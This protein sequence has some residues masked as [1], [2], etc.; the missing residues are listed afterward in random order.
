MTGVPTEALRRSL[1][2]KPN[3]KHYTS[4]AFD[5][6]HDRGELLVAIVMGA[7][8]RIWETRLA[9][10]AKGN[11]TGV[12]PILVIEEGA[13]AAGQLLRLLTRAIAYLPPVDLARSED[14]RVGK[15]CVSQCKSRWSPFH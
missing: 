3:P 4:A 11:P 9:P 12:S 10:L 1:R 15:E 13:S 8:V 2:I 6:A 5:E 7:F 14:R